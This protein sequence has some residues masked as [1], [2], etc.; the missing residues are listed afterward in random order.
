MQGRNLPR[1]LHAFGD[2]SRAGLLIQPTG[3]QLLT[4]ARAYSGKKC[5]ANNRRG[6][7][8]AGLPFAVADGSAVGLLSSHARVRLSPAARRSR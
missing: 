1:E 7:P 5:R 3:V 4:N 2:G 6:S 8:P